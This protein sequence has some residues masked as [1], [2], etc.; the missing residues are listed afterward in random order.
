MKT[1]LANLTPGRL[2]LA[3]G[4][5]LVSVGCRQIVDFDDG[6]TPG[7]HDA[8]EA[9]ANSSSNL[10]SNVCG[11]PYATTDC[12]TCAAAHCR[13]ESAACAREQACA[14]ESSCLANCGGDP[15]CRAHCAL[16]APVSQSSDASELAACLAMQC[17]EACDLGC[18]LG[19][20]DYG[21]YPPEAAAEC[22]TCVVTS[23]CDAARACAASA[24]CDAFTRCTSVCRTDDCRWMCREN[25]DAGR[26]LASSLA[27]N[28]ATCDA[29]CGRGGNWSCVGQVSWP[30]PKSD[31][32][33]LTLEFN[34]PQSMKGYAGVD[35][36]VC[37]RSDR[38]CDHAKVEDKTVASGR[39]V[40]PFQ[41]GLDG[42]VQ[43]A[44]Q[45]QEF[46][47][48]LMYWGFPLSEAHYALIDD[49]DDWRHAFHFLTRDALKGVTDA[50]EV[51]QDPSRGFVLVDPVDCQGQ[52]APGVVLTLDPPD[53][54]VR[55]F[56]G[57]SLGLSETDRSNSFATFWNVPIGAVSVIATPDAVGKPSSRQTV[58]VR[59]G[60]GT[61]VHMLPTP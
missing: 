30:K 21:K 2:V 33:T 48:G 24:D 39:V 15:Q 26:A 53:P 35:V 20:G 16:D 56:Y 29:A 47:N 49:T 34:D 42:Y 44:S 6:S 31:T 22:H 38:Y 36:A 17:E 23:A 27:T 37:D 9:C 3:A 10:T 58:Y 54:G 8:G 5:V 25:H 60:L 13:S 18:G 11:L 12:A 46:V 41:N 32:V 14:L 40:L 1:H 61:I 52:P 55:V 19:L 57:L 51:I 45:A 43:V 7:G 59:A 50:A 4:A 28:L